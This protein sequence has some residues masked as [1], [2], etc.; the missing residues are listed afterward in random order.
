MDGFVVSDFAGKCTISLPKLY[1]HHNLPISRD[2]IPTKNDVDR[3]D[4][5]KSIKKGIPEADPEAPIALLI[6]VIVQQH[7]DHWKL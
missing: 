4:H 6:G 5:L 3:W 1:T 2:E 7:L